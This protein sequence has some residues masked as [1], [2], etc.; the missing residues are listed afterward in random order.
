M[1]IFRTVTGWHESAA[2]YATH[3]D[4]RDPREIVVSVQI[5][6][7]HDSE[8]FARGGFTRGRN[9]QTELLGKFVAAAPAWAAKES[10][11]GQLCIAY[12]D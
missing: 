10:D 1:H 2:N 3:Y 6:L 8:S 11:W 12:F 9:D 5:D 7:Q 4:A